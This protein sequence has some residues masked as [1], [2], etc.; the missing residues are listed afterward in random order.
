[1][2]G[3]G[4][5]IGPCSYAYSW[6]YD[7]YERRRLPPPR[8]DHRLGRRRRWTDEEKAWIVA[9][10]LD[11]RTSAGPT[12]SRPSTSSPLPCICLRFRGQA[13]PWPPAQRG[14]PLV[15]AAPGTHQSAKSRRTPA[16]AGAASRPRSSA[17]PRGPARR[18]CWRAFDTVRLPPKRPL[19]ATNT[20]TLTAPVGGQCYHPLYRSTVVRHRVAFMWPWALGRAD[21]RGS[22]RGSGSR[23]AR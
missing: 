23:A 17:Q 1:M 15:E 11:P 19:C 7:W 14:P 20:L 21:R 6:Y 18:R 3:R 9:E 22:E 4:G 12:S 10:S 2:K 13:V 16:R 8:G 5:T